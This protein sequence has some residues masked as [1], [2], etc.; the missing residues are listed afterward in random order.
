MALLVQ[1]GDSLGLGSIL[2]NFQISITIWNVTEGVKKNFVTGTNLAANSLQH[3]VCQTIWSCCRLFGVE[4]NLKVNTL[5]K[6]EIS[7]RFEQYN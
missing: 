3:Y 6:S 5:V 4:R 1:R 2:I 7:K